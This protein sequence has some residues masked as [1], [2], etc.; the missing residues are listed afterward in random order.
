M[1][2]FAKAAVL[3]TAVILVGWG[4]IGCSQEPGADYL[5]TDVTSLMRGVPGEKYKL[6]NPEVIYLGG[7]VAIV[8]DSET[9]MVVEGDGLEGI[10]NPLMASNFTL[11]GAKAGQPYVHLRAEGVIANEVLTEI[12]NNASH[13]L[14]NYR[15][16]EDELFQDYVEVDIAEIAFDSRRA[17]EEQLLETQTMIQG[18]LVVTE[19]DGQKR[20]LVENGD[21][22]V[23][24]EP[25]NRNLEIFLSLLEKKGGRFVAAG[26]LTSMRDWDDGTEMD[27]EATHILGD[28]EV[29]YLRYGMIAAP[30]M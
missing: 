2:L 16:A 23:V 24:L 30:N 12:T 29:G 15:P 14:P 5:E 22:K 26:V 9:M 8:M 20:Y 13:M 17:I 27:R 18:R 19:E 28:Y 21:S 3:G 1:K 7:D 6:L 10:L 4:V 25:V 11:L